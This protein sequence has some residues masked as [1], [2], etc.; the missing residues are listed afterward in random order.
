MKKLISIILCFSAL[1]CLAGC[2]KT[3]KKEDESTSDVPESTTAQSTVEVTDVTLPADLTQEEISETVLVT[4]EAPEPATVP[5]ATPVTTDNVTQTPSTSA[6]IPSTTVVI[7][8][9]EYEKT[10]DMAFTDNASNKFIKAV[11]S[12]YNVSAKNLVALY[13][14]PENDSN[15]VLQF[16]GTKNAD[17]TLKRNKDTLVAIYSIDSALT[18]KRASDDDLNEYS[19]AEM[20]VMFISVTSFIMPEFEELK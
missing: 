3:I 6:T 2:E 11:A 8:S 14:V 9:K 15:I 18:S 17:G 1:L 10:G 12:K 5:T 16:D 19:Y 13:T 7:T 4:A 20:K